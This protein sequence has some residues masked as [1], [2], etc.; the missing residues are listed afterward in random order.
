M[1]GYGVRSL[2]RKTGR[3]TDRDTEQL[4][5]SCTASLLGWKA[6]STVPAQQPCFQSDHKDEHVQPP[7]STNIRLSFQAQNPLGW[8]L[9]QSGLSQRQG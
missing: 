5:P 3:E 7:T 6:A 4:F 1:A 9:R 2:L 8:A